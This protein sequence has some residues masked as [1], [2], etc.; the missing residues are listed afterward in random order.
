MAWPCKPLTGCEIPA[1]VVGGRCC[2]VTLQIHADILQ[3]CNE[4][5]IL[6]FNEGAV[7]VFLEG[8]PQFLLCVHDD[9]SVPCDGFTYGFP[10]HEEQAYGFIFSGNEYL[11]SVF[12]QDKVL[13]APRTHPFE[14]RN[15]LFLR[16]H[17]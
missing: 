1:P 14:Y 15:S 4:S 7:A 16:L 8:D 3:R 13:V 6:M 12:E 2:R 17:R 5:Y 10:G 11:F 9:G